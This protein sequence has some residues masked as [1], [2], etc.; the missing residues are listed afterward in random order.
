[1]VQT[2]PSPSPMPGQRGHARFWG[3]A[4]HADGS[5]TIVVLLVMA[6][7]IGLL[8]GLGARH[9]AHRMDSDAVLEADTPA[10]AKRLGYHRL[11]DL[12]A[13]LAQQSVALADV[14]AADAGAQRPWENVETGNRGLI[15][16]SAETRRADG[17]LCRTLARRTLINGAFSRSHGAACLN[18]TE[19]QRTG[20]WRAD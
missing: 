10:E 13:D 5:D 18:G 2:V 19:W 7:V 6:V 12:Q 14:L 20:G 1:M 8:G 3:Y 15:W 4:L 17:T 11:R 16:A 9:M